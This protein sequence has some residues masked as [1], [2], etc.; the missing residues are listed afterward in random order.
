MESCEVLVIG[1]GPAGS[2][3]AAKLKQENVD[4][5]LMDKQVFPREKPCAGWITPVVLEK[6]GI[7]ADEYRSTLLLQEI[8]NFR[9]GLIYGT[10]SVTSYNQTVSYG[11]LRSEFDHYLLQRSM[12]RKKL[13]EAVVTLERK[14][15]GWIVNNNLYARLIV[16]AGGHHCPVARLLG[17]KIRMEEIIA[18]QVSEFAISPE[19]EL[20]CPITPDTPL[21]F[22]CRDMKGY[23]WLFRKGKFLNIGLGRM[24]RNHLGQHVKDFCKF[25]QQRGYLTGSFNGKFR[26]HAYL[27][28]DRQ[29]QRTIVDDGVML[30]GDAAGLAH[31]QSGEGILPAVESALIAADTILDCNRK[32]S[33]QNL[34]I[35]QSRLSSHFEDISNFPS[36]PI[37]SKFYRFLGARLL[38]SSWFTQ[39]IVLERWFLH[40]N[41]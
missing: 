20:Q 15:G 7:D 8:R 28:Y 34:Q 13:G 27:L 35:Y 6:L 5:L 16:G 4:V 22:F 26:G 23:G 3:C 19:E 12:A 29:R 39:N 30:L 32:Y 21:I 40:I 1:G 38:C 37:L 41:K 36:S 17:A 24:D 9:T 18:A 11:I 31:P 25:L 33:G 2:T 14:K 10:E